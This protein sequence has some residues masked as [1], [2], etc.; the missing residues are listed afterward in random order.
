MTR[1]M[2]VH[3]GPQHTPDALCLFYPTIAF[4]RSD[5]KKGAWTPETSVQSGTASGA[6][7][8]EDRA[9]DSITP[10]SVS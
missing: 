10:A 6:T 4:S 7:S 9:R 5:V 3:A 2:V 8:S 1:L